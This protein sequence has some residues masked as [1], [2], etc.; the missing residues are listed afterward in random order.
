MPPY[1]HPGF[2][3]TVTSYSL[4][5]LLYI[6]FCVFCVSFNLFWPR[7]LCLFFINKM[8]LNCVR[9]IL[10]VLAWNV[11]MCCHSLAHKNRWSI[12]TEHREKTIRP[13]SIYIYSFATKKLLQVHDIVF[14]NVKSGIYIILLWRP[15]QCVFYHTY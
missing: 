10:H 15:D 7:E 11:V 2:L 5:F 12:K 9:G 3:P 1:W 14:V 13:L 8:R 4:M 6:I